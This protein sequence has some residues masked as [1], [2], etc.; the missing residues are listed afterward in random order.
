MHIKHGIRSTSH[1]LLDHISYIFG[2]S[3]RQFRTFVVFAARTRS[4]YSVWVLGLLH[5]WAI[6]TCFCWNYSLY[7]ILSDGS[8]NTSCS[9]VQKRFTVGWTGWISLARTPRT[10]IYGYNILLIIF[11]IKRIFE[12]V[13]IRSVHPERIIEH[14]LL[15]CYFTLSSQRFLSIGA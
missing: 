10:G 9:T 15:C 4:V 11:L 2:Y 5:S 13:L 1:S 6:R 7:I 12:H 3:V 8:P 14:G